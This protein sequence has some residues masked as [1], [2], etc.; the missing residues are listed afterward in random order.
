MLSGA[1]SATEPMYVLYDSA[2]LAYGA[3]D[4]EN[5]RSL[6][7]DSDRVCHAGR[8]AEAVAEAVAGQQTRVGLRLNRM[9]VRPGEV[10]IIAGFNGF[11]PHDAV[12]D[13]HL[14]VEARSHWGAQRDVGLPNGEVTRAGRKD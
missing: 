11:I 5:A 7:V 14:E 6:M 10:R 8:C 1:V 2:W 9:A 3:N 12:K 13:A 4:V